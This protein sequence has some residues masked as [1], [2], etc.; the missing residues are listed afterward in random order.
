MILISSCSSIELNS[1]STSSSQ[2]ACSLTDFFRTYLSPKGV[3][4]SGVRQAYFFNFLSIQCFMKQL[5]ISSK[6]LSLFGLLAS[7]IIS[8]DLYSTCLDLLLQHVGGVQSALLL[9]V[10][11]SIQSF[12]FSLF[13]SHFSSSYFLNLA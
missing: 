10:V 13:Q 1:C 7:F 4:F 11:F 12:P 8:L 5:L 9:K 6:Q 2:D 3:Y